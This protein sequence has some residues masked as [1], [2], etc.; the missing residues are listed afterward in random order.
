MARERQW[1]KQGNRTKSKRGLQT[2]S[3]LCIFSLEAR[4]TLLT[5]YGVCLSGR[6]AIK[7]HKV[8]LWRVEVGGDQGVDRASFQVVAFFQ[9]P[10]SLPSV[11]V[12][13]CSDHYHKEHTRYFRLRSAQMTFFTL[14]TS[15]KALCPSSCIIEVPRITNSTY[16]FRR[17]QISPYLSL[18]T[19]KLKTKDNI[20]VRLHQALNRPNQIL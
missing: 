19:L 16:E 1:E 11:C 20:I 6:A 12:C 18:S 5:P 14:I 9:D 13:Q 3:C 2:N 7:Y 15:L 8:W 4:V 10:N 17:T